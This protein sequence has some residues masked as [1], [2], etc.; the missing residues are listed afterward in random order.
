MTLLTAQAGTVTSPRQAAKL[1]LWRRWP[2]AAVRVAAVVLIAAAG[3]GLWQLADTGL[4]TP[5][6]IITVAEGQRAQITLSDGTTVWLNSGTT[7]SYPTAFG[8]RR[9]TVELDG[10]GYFEVTRNERA[11]FVV[12][13]SK[14]DVEVLGTKF[15]VDAYTS[16]DRFETALFEGSVRLHAPGDAAEHAVTLQPDQKALLSGGKFR[17][18]ALGDRNAY[19]WRDG[20]I[21]FRDASF[22]MIMERLST[23]FGVE[24]VVEN[25]QLAKR[26]YTGKFRQIDGLDYALSV[27]NR[28]V[29]FTVVHDKERRRVVIR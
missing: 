24:I 26:S 11:P 27:L 21:Y 18:V 22:D 2:Q 13:T 29:A 12:R 25:P 16:T 20:I 9:R 6:N 14:A 23:Y 15:N 8:R 3:A 17:I 1:P 7:L 5:D 10:E 28:E 19:L 4:R